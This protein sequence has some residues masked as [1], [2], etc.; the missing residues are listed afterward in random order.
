MGSSTY[1]TP[2]RLPWRF[3]VGAKYVVEGYGGDE[4]NFQVIARYVVMPGGQRIN[5]PADISSP[6][7]ALA[8]RR[9]ANAKQSRPK[10]QAP[11]NGKKIAERRGTG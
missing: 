7:R 11:A 9:R 10:N 3:P 1:R 5:V 6:P 8:F 2:T 4:G